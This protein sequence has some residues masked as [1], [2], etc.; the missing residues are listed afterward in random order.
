M[1]QILLKLLKFDYTASLLL[2]GAR[3]V[4]CLL[5]CQKTR[6]SHQIRLS[7]G[8]TLKLEV[9]KRAEQCS[10]MFSRSLSLRRVSDLV[11][12]QVVA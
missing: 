10:N 3:R 11:R 7:R 5:L 1:Q 6:R 12:V 9:R 8:K 4:D 2:F